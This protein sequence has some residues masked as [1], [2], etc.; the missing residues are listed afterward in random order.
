MAFRWRDD[1]GLLLVVFGF[2]S[3]S[4]TKKMSELSPFEFFFLDP[5]MQ[6]PVEKNHLNHH[7]ERDI[8]MLAKLIIISFQQKL[9]KLKYMYSTGIN[10]LQLT[11]RE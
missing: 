2:S 8:S 10:H 4:S 6:V 3:S 7:H 1:A 5:R 11:N 9:K